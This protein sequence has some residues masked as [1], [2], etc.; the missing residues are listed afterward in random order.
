MTN[1]PRLK[2]FGMNL[3]EMGPLALPYYA[4]LS[5][6]TSADI[7]LSAETQ[8]GFIDFINGVYI[9]NLDNGSNF[10]ITCGG[11]NQKV[12]CPA[13]SQGYFSLMVPNPP[14]FIAQS[15][16]GVKVPLI[17]YNIPIFPFVWSA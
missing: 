15:G 13:N 11:T 12:I 2:I 6:A 10:S 3:S 8:Q 9:D 17:F 7:D 1:N 16:G 4:D 5:S 14:T